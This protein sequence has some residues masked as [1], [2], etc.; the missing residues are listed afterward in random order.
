M[1]EIYRQ[2]TER[3]IQQLVDGTPPWRQPWD[4]Q[5]FGVPRNA[6]TKKPYRGL[7]ILLLWDANQSGFSSN[8]FATYRQWQAIGG[9]VRRGERAATKII[10]WKTWDQSVSDLDTGTEREEKR[11]VLREYNVFA[12]EQCE[13]DAVQRLHAPQRNKDFVDYQPADDAIA[14]TGAKI[15]HGGSRAYYN[16]ESDRIFMPPKQAFE[17]QQHYYGTLLHEAIHFSGHPARLNRLDKLSRFGDHTYAIEELVA[18]MG[19]AFLMAHLGIP[20][21]DLQNQASYLDS[22]LAVLRADASAIITAST[23]ASKAADFI[24]SFSQ[25]RKTKVA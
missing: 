2:V 9:Q 24:L 4:S 19:A 11:F 13:G 25:T 18:E 3:I 21:S 14:A 7:N 10:Y 8:L 1:Q 16:A 6:V 22:W 15:L 23:Q 20:N 12:L 5:A 17:A